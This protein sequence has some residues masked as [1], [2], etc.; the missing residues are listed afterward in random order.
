MDPPPGDARLLSH[1]LAS[2]QAL[3]VG[4]C[5]N[6]LPGQRA[7]LAVL[8]GDWLRPSGVEGRGEAMGMVSSQ[9]VRQISR[10]NE[11]DMGLNSPKGV[12]SLLRLTWTGHAGYAV[13]C[14]HPRQL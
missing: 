9:R 13:R 2:R 11:R 10:L 1:R 6:G 14:S 8:S 3:A 4:M 5:G 12:P 7:T